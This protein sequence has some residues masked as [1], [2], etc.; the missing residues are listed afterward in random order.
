MRGIVFHDWLKHSSRSHSSLPE[1]DVT[2][3]PKPS[4]EE[5]LRLMPGN[6]EAELG[7]ADT[8]QK[9]GDHTFGSQLITRLR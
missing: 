1:W 2:R 3:K 8:Y 9:S 5:A 7:L 4:F 6:P